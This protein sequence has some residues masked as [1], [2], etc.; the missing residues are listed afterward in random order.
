MILEQKHLST[1]NGRM[2]YFRGQ[3]GAFLKK[4]NLKKMHKCVKTIQNRNFK[5][6]VTTDELK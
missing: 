6:S 3:L 5:N 1:E 2:Q 4:I